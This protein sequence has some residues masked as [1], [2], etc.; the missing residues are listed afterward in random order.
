MRP[1]R[2]AWAGH[3]RGAA[4]PRRHADRSAGRASPTT[5]GPRTRPRPGPPTMYTPSTLGRARENRT[6]RPL[7][8][9][10][11]DLR[12][13]PVGKGGRGG[14]RG[15]RPAGG[16]GL[17]TVQRRRRGRGRCWA[18]MDENTF[19][20][21]YGVDI[22]MPAKVRPRARLSTSTNSSRRPTAHRRQDARRRGGT[23]ATRGRS[24]QRRLC[25]LARSGGP[26]PRRGGPAASDHADRQ[27]AGLPAQR[28]HRPGARRRSAGGDSP[29]SANRALR[30][31]ENGVD[32]VIAQ[33]HEA[34]GTPGK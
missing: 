12:V 33:G 28:R 7:R 27:R 31:A 18:R 8:H 24:A 2:R 15:G 17:R 21:Q 22:V 10:V 14:Q 1:G 16:A 9:P 32:I 5:A 3:L 13:H 25:R 4:P 29:G 26:Q 23:A 20:L 30:H 11:P 6:L 19:G 34:G